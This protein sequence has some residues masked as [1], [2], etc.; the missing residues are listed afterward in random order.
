MRKTVCLSF[1][2]FIFALT[3]TAQ[4]TA[5]KNMAL[6]PPKATKIPKT[7]TAHN[8]ERVDEYYWLNNPDDPKVIE[9][10]NA[11]NGYYKKMTAHTD[12]LKDILFEEMKARIK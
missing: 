6:T 10:L 5:D 3:L 8:D 2:Y 12:G 7:L 11:E 9:Y 1:A 4:N